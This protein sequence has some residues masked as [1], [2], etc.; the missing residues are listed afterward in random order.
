MIRQHATRAA[1]KTTDHYI[2]AIARG[3]YGAHQE[4]GHWHRIK[5]PETSYRET[6]CGLRISGAAALTPW[7]PPAGEAICLDCRQLAE[8]VRS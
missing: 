6:V 5:V 8:A 1:T 2:A 4:L 3:A 7:L